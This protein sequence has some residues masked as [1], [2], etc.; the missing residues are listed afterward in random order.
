MSSASRRQIWHTA[1]DRSEVGSPLTGASVFFSSGLISFS[2]RKR[3][4]VPLAPGTV[5]GTARF[6]AHFP[7]HF[8]PMHRESLNHTECVVCVCI[9]CVS[10]YEYVCICIYV[11]MCVY[12]CIYA[13]CVSMY[14][15]V[16]VCVCLKEGL[17]S[18]GRR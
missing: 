6:G 4:S 3:K 11:Q 9:V 18:P 10:V 8:N 13:V 15:R 1:S 5:H 7:V 12:V 16:C 14:A 17:A 2:P